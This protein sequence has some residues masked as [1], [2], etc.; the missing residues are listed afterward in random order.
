MR[1]K[2]RRPPLPARQAQHALCVPVL[3]R[4]QAHAP[5]CSTAALPHLPP[6]HSQPCL[7][8]GVRSPAEWAH[9]SPP[10]EVV[11]LLLLLTLFPLP[12]P[13]APFLPQ[14]VP[15]DELAA[16]VQAVLAEVPGDQLTAMTTKPLI[17]KMGG[18]GCLPA[19]PACFT[20]LLACTCLLAGCQLS[21]CHS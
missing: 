8:H 19:C 17:K 16:A 6:A 4:L 1:L 2:R 3:P 7:H 12:A 13:R 21:S 11:L 14:Q 9:C 20:P 5:A 18:L 10:L 15:A